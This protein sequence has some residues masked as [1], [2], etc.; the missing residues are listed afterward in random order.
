MVDLGTTALSVSA[1]EQEAIRA[2]IRAVMADEDLSMTDVARGAAIPYGTFSSWMGATYNGRGDR[3]GAQAKRWI[4]ARKIQQETRALAPSAPGFLMTPSA[5]AFQNVFAHAQHMVDLAVITGGPGVGKTMA[6]QAYRARTPNV[7]L[8]T[9]E[10]CFATP[11][12]LLDDVSETL[13]IPREYTAQMASR[14]VV[15]KL[16]DSGALLIVDE[17]QHLSTAALDQLRTIH[18][19]AHVGV[20]LV[21]NETIYAR[22]EGGT[23]TAAFAQLFSRVGFRLPRGAKPLAK[24]VDVLLDA[25]GVQSTPERKLLHTIA[26][27]P[28]ALRGM[29]KTLRMAHMMA[30]AEHVPLAD[31][32]ILVAYRQLSATDLAEAA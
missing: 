1:E 25:W 17:A 31:N 21:G 30:A 32:H 9:A 8:M 14:A 6:A 11:R 3:V 28:G 19:L 15:R 27:K 29:T 12:M 10:P 2:Q 7:W 24:D 20:V 13:G 22:L 16:R 18:D 26:R 5:E 23:R 4:E